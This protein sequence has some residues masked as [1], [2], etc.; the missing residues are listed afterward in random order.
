MEECYHGR[1][2][3]GR[4]HRK[5]LPPCYDAKI[6]RRI[7]NKKMKTECEKE[8]NFCQISK[9][10]NVG[11]SKMVENIGKIRHDI[12]SRFVRKITPNQ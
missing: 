4:I 11:P 6:Y 9:I 7:E 1:V 10:F 2:I 8:P 12:L 5:L 3:R